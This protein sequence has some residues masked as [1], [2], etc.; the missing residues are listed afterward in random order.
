[1]EYVLS[2]PARFSNNESWIGK[3]EFGM[4]IYMR[5]W[6]ISYMVMSKEI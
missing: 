5:T 1:M 2:F 6:Q 3:E 4:K